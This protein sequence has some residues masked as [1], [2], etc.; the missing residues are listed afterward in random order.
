V[1]ILQHTISDKF[2]KGE[3]IM[4]KNKEPW[5][6][7]ILSERCMQY[8]NEACSNPEPKRNMQHEL[9]G[10]IYKSELLEDKDNWFYETILKKLTEKMFYQNCSNYYEEYIEKEKIPP[11]FQLN[12]LWVNY[13]KKHEFNPLHFHNGG[14]G[15]SFVIFMKIPTYWKEQYALPISASSNDPAASNFS[16]VWTKRDSETVDITNFALSPEDEGR[17]LFFPAWLQHQ[18]YPFYE[19]EEQRVTISGNIDLCTNIPHNYIKLEKEENPVGEYEL[20]NLL[21]QKDQTL[22]L[23]EERAQ[24]LRKEIEGLREAM[25]KLQK[26]N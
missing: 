1:R 12:M 10:N 18:V 25:D 8:L 11:K 7:I 13:Q 9:A 21:D 15:Y 20:R 24:Q 3:K 23:T 26:L 22:H 2:R 16:F 17:M 19:C 4:N 5:F 6:D 14:K